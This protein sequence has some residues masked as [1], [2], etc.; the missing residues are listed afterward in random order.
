MNSFLAKLSS[1]ERALV[2]ATVTILAA[3][4]LV[5][6]GRAGYNTIRELDRQIADRELEIEGL[7]QQNM[8]AAAVNAAYARVVT[9]HSSALTIAE[10]H[11]ALR[12]E[13]FRL[14]QVDIPAKGDKPART[15]Q[16]VRIPTL[17]EG[18]LTQE[19]GHREYQIRFQIPTAG[20]D[21]LL[22]FLERI[23]ESDQLLRIDNLDIAR[24]PDSKGVQAMVQITRTVLDDPQAVAA[25]KNA[26]AAEDG[27]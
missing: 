1:R 26:A 11:D 7:T 17:Q 8:Q 23:E 10:I 22:S 2:A 27:Q 16:L 18:Q 24:P 4:A 5:F 14:T 21:F 3:A 12:R 20:L 15:M 6:G 25:G 19:E 9:V 13:I